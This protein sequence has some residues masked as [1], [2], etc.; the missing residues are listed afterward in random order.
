MCWAEEK[1]LLFFAADLQSFS[2]VL[3]L[4]TVYIGAVLKVKK[5]SSGNQC[6]EVKGSDSAIDCKLSPSL[7]Y[8][9]T[10]FVLQ[11]NHFQQILQTI[12]N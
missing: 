1:T 6:L 3:N 7:K 2:I 11:K 10:K 12:I 5:K 8:L 9:N 4:N